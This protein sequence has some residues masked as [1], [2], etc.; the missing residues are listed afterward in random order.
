MLCSEFLIIENVIVVLILFAVVAG[1]VW[2][3]IHA[4]KRGKA[5]I[6]CPYANKCGSKC[7]GEC[8]SGRNTIDNKE[9]QD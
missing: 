3:F 7:N 8:S 2:Y 9:I 6:T 1:T 4:K 5:C